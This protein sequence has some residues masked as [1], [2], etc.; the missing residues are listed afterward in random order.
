MHRVKLKMLL[1]S[2][3]KTTEADFSVAL[4][5]GRILNVSIF[6]LVKHISNRAVDSKFSPDVYNTHTEKS[7]HLNEVMCYYS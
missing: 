3:D 2:L 6:F 4:I 1:F 7:R 5:A